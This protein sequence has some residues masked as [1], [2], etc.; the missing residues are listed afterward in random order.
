MTL[1]ILVVSDTLVVRAIPD[2]SEAREILA[3]LAALDMQ[4]AEDLRMPSMP[5]IT[6]QAL[7]YIQSWWPLL[8]AIRRRRW[9]PLGF[10]L[11]QLITFS[12][13]SVR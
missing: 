8:E 3:I 13:W 7:L 5:L 2:M 12:R 6:Q 1:V 10:I 4:V 9:P 11:T